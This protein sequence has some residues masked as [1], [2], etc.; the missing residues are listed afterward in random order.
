MRKEALATDAA[1]ATQRQGR[2]DQVWVTRQQAAIIEAVGNQPGVTI[3]ELRKQVRSTRR[4]L[5]GQAL[6]KVLADKLVEVRQE[7]KADRLYPL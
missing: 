6:D 2:K 4:L 1:L 7:G 3:T 5:W